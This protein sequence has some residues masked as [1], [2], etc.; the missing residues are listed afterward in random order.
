MANTA[1]S[2]ERLPPQALEAEISVLGAM[3]LDKA[4]VGAVVEILDESSFY[5]ESNR[6]IFKAIISLFERNEPA[7]LV[8]VTEE[9]RREKK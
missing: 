8:T 1:V 5:R 9:L 2:V 6:Q 7:D 4:A 3:L